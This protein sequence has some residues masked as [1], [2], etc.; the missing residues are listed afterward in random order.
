MPCQSAARRG[1]GAVQPLQLPLRAAARSGDHRMGQPPLRRADP[2]SGR[3]HTAS[4]RDRRRRPVCPPRADRAAVRPDRTCPGHLD[5]AARGAA[6]PDGSGAGMPRA[7][8]WVNHIATAEL[9]A[10]SRARDRPDRGSGTDSWLPP[11]PGKSC[12][13]RHHRAAGPA[14]AC[15]VR[16]PRL[17][18]GPR[19]STKR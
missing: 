16:G 13:S 7:V 19:A 10:G 2:E 12:D 4:R 14:R 5:R 18:D 6:D 3:R 9:A 17:V 11:Y 1:A 15:R 8:G